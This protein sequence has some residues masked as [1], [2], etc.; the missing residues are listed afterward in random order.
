VQAGPAHDLA[1]YPHYSLTGNN[2]V[3]LR[4][5]DADLK[6][7]DTYLGDE[8]SLAVYHWINSSTGW[9]IIGGTVDTVKNAIYAPITEPGVY[10]AFTNNIITDVDDDTQ[11]NTHPYRFELSQNYPNPFNPVTTIEYRLT[12]RSRVT[13]EVYNVVGQRVRTLVDEEQSAGSYR[14]TWDG[15]D[16]CGRPVATG[17]YLYRFCAGDYTETKKMLL[18]K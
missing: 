16:D 8:T 1:V 13:I 6:L 11:G 7:G 5:D 3:V 18:V 17:I 14:I 9:Q 12:E 2:S 15:A 4:Y 10:A